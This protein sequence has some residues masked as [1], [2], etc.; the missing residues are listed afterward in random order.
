MPL[1]GLGES[2]RGGKNSLT[3]GKMNNERRL[4]ERLQSLLEAPTER[5]WV[6]FYVTEFA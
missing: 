2:K 6:E 5:E 4:R 3:G 1:I